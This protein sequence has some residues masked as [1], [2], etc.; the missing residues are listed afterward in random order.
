MKSLSSERCKYYVADLSQ[1]VGQS[2][3]LKY[4]CPGLIRVC[5]FA[6][7]CLLTILLYKSRLEG[8][9]ICSFTQNILLAYETYPKF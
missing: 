9:Y 2:L 3:T 1:S 5:A 7:Y 6:D 4:V 8:I